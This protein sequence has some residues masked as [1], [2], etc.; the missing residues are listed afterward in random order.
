MVKIR[1]EDGDYKRYRGFR[2]LAIAGSKVRLP[3]N[4]EIQEHFGAISSSN[5][6]EE[7][8]G[9]PNYAQVSVLY[10]VLNRV[11]LTGE[12]AKARTYEVDWGIKHL[13]P[14]HCGDLILCDRNYASYRFL[15]EREPIDFVIRCSASSFQVARA[16]L[17]G[18]GTDSQ[19]VNLKISNQ[20]SIQVR[21]VR[22]TLSTREYEVFVTSL[23]DELTYPNEL[24]KELY[25]L[26]WGIETFYGFLKTRLELENFSGKTVKSLYQNCYATVYLTGLESRLTLETNQILSTKNPNVNSQQVNHNVSFHVIKSKAL[27]LL[28]SDIPIPKVLKKLRALFLTNPTLNK[29]KPHTPRK[30]RTARH[31]LHYHRTQ[32]KHCF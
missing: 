6:H 25:Y 1:Y 9:E 19:V 22:V 17:K 21:F 31:L 24:F 32:R 13:G 8:K 5:Q 28:L 26:R 16:M 12:F 29:K 27:N 3:D 18:Q 23:A 7:V 14:P 10:E 30:K 4:Q 15:E 20:K 2:F 11:A